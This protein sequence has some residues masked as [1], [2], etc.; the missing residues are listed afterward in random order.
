MGTLTGE[1]TPPFS[2][3]PTFSVKVNS[4]RIYSVSWGEIQQHNFVFM[5]YEAH[6]FSVFSFLL[7]VSALISYF[8][9]SGTCLFSPS[10]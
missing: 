5:P 2:F 1:A 6:I 8:T 3:L 9:F 4:Y 7:I 10:I